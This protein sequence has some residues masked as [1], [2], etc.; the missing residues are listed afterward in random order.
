MCTSPSLRELSG[1]PPA[2][3]SRGVRTSGNI[4]RKSG[5]NAGLPTGRLHPSDKVLVAP[6]G[7]TDPTVYGERYEYQ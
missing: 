1:A 3:G 7:L 6:S 4:N 2:A 5:A